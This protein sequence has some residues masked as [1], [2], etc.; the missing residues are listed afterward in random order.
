MLSLAT[1]GC[2]GGG[3]TDDGARCGI[4]VSYDDNIETVTGQGTFDQGTVVSPATVA[5]PYH[6]LDEWSGDHALVGRPFP[7]PSKE[8]RSSP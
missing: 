1:D 7:A 8:M 2:N 3:S 5:K 6:V 4:T